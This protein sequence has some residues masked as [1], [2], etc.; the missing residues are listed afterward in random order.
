MPRRSGDRAQLPQLYHELSHFW[1]PRDLDVPSP[2]WNE[3]LA[4]YLQYRLAR[5]LDGFAG[6]AA[7]IERAS[8]RVCAGETRA[9]LERTP[10][11]RFGAEGVT[12]FSYRVGFLMFTALEALVGPERARRRG[13]GVRPGPHGEGRHDGRSDRGHLPR[14]RSTKAFGAFFRDWMETSAWVGPVCSASSFADALARWK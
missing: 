3:G 14:R 6:T 4:T 5:E 2:R 11:A 7:A 1:N 9:R 8:S 10:F 12:D 13:P